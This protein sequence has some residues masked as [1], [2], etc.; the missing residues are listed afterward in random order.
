MLLLSPGLLAAEG[1][2]AW[3]AGEGR[4]LP[5]RPAATTAVLGRGEAE[6]ERLNALNIPL[7]ATEVP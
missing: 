1:S 7:W 3:E 2:L 5:P 4:L 6:S